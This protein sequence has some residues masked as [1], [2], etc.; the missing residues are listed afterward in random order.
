MGYKVE[1]VDRTYSQ[2]TV[3][4]LDRK[5]GTLWGGASEQG[6]DYGIGL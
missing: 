4:W 2:I 3:I 6:D 1:I 5:N